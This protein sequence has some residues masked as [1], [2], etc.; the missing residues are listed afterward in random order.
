M[1]RVNLLTKYSV[2]FFLLLL[3]VIIILAKLVNVSNEALLVSAVTAILMY[4]FTSFFIHKEIR[5]PLRY[6]YSFS[7]KLKLPAESS[8]DDDDFDKKSDE[9]NEL[10]EDLESMKTGRVLN[11]E[12]YE[13]INELCLIAK[14]TLHEINT[15]KVFRI[16]RNEFMG[17]VAHELR[18]PIFAIQLSIETLLDG[19]INDEE[20]NEDFLSRALNQTKRLKELV[21]DLIS[22]S[23]FE[24]GVKMSMRYFPI[25]KA[26]EET[27]GEL[28]N[29]ASNKNVHLEFAN[30]Y[31]EDLTAFGDEKRLRQVIINLVDNAIKYT[32][33]EGR[34]IVSL[35]VKEKEVS[36]IVKDDGIG[37]PKKD[38]P[39]IFERFYRVDKA[40]SRDIGGSGLGLSIVKHILEAHS[41]HI[42]VESEVDKGTK[43]EFSL[44]R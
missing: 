44:K 25:A 15:A 26:V 8:E 2:L 39:R 7:G 1:K 34:V 33:Q 6:L 3:I 18:T 20:V 23:K 36:V 30:G 5:I 38:L 9:L 37:I 14:R 41:S 35:D 43:F 42:K 22:I 17:N 12:I 21:D 27:V 13:T 40:R 24:T 16:N 31:A 32:P 4:A 11:K 10:I 19:A 28:S 29:L